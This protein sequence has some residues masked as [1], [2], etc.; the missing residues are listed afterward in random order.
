MGRIN[1]FE[2]HYSNPNMDSNK[3]SLE[4]DLRVQNFKINDPLIKDDP[5]LQNFYQQQPDHEKY[6]SKK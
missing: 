5:I 4:M 2:S 3:S 1:F 6:G